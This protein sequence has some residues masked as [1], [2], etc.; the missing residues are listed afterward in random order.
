MSPRSGVLAGGN[1]IVDHVKLIDRWPPQD[2]LANIAGQMSSNGGSA[3][4]VLKNLARMGASF[5]LE[6]VGLVGNDAA[7]QFVRDDCAQHRIDTSRLRTSTA[8]PTS[9]T[10][11][12]T[13]QA[14]GRRTFFHCR[15]ANAEL[16]PE[17]FDFTRTQAK[18]FHLG[19]LLLLDRLHDLR[20]D[21]TPA[22]ID[23]FRAARAAQQVHLKGVKSIHRGMLT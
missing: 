16:A 22:A 11:V 19:Y 21:A 2:A 13:E 10:D 17:H 18:I 5:P 9:Y 8:A 4:N 14:T 12:M 7:G 6:A 23:T 20:A 3:Y 1:W 15:G